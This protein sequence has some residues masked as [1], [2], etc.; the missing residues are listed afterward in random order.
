VHIAGANPLRDSRSEA[1]RRVRAAGVEI[2]S[3]AMEVDR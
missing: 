3:D 2:A 1:R